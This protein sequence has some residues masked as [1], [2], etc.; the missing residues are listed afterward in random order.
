M[1]IAFGIYIYYIQILICGVWIQDLTTH[2]SFP[3]GLISNLT[4]S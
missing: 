2:D 4:R 3:I 1:R